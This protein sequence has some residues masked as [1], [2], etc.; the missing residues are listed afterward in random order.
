MKP[1]DF[2]KVAVLMGGRSAERAVRI[3][4]PHPQG[5]LVHAALGERR[6]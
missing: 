2:G 6:V 1:S 5:A 3:N 4:A